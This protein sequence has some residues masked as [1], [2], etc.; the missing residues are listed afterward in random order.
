M[1]LFTTKTI[2]LKT[3]KLKTF[4]GLANKTIVNYTVVVKHFQK[5]TKRKYLLQ[6]KVKKIH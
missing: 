3:I 2:I 4:N 1:M 6:K 5:A